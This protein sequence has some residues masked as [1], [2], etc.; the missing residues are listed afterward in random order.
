VRPGERRRFR[1]AGDVAGRRTIALLLGSTAFLVVGGLIMVLSASS[2][3]AYAQYGDSFLFFQRQATY[4]VGGVLG[5][6]LTSRMRYRAWQRLAVP[7]LAVTV[8]L[9]AL[10]LHPTAGVAAY[11]S[12]RWIA[13]G[14]VTIQPSEIAKLALVLFAAMILTRKWGRLHDVGHLALPLA[15]VALLVCGMVS[16]RTWARR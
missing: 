3:S 8:I 1:S 16:S 4:A 5:L 12:S 14:P 11:G 2:V 15:P 6:L 10:V 7:L 9:L 13:L